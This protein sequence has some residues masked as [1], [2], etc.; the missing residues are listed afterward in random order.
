MMGGTDAM[1]VSERATGKSSEP[2][3]GQRPDDPEETEDEAESG[4][5]RKQQSTTGQDTPSRSQSM[6]TGT[7]RGDAAATRDLLEDE[8][9]KEND[10]TSSDDA[11][12]MAAIAS[13]L[14]QLA[15][16][17]KG[18]RHEGGAVATT[19]APTAA[20]VAD[21]TQTLTQLMSMVADLTASTGND[22]D[23]RQV[24]N[25]EVETE[26]AG[27][28]QSPEVVV[29]HQSASHEQGRVVRRDRG[30]SGREQRRDHSRSSHS[31]DSRDGHGDGR[32]SRQRHGRGARRG[33]RRESRQVARREQHDDAR[34]PAQR[35]AR[36]ESPPSSG[37]DD[38]SGSSSEEERG[39]A[40]RNYEESSSGSASSSPSSSDVSSDEQDQARG[41]RGRDERRGRHGRR[42]RHERRERRDHEP[43]RR[44]RKKSVK[45]L[46]LPTFTPSPKVSVSTWID[47]VELA[48]KGA[49]ESG[50]GTWS[51]KALYFILGNKLMESASKWWVD[52]D[53]RLSDRRR[54]WTY[55]KRALLRRYGEKLDKSAAEWRVSMRRMMPG[56]THADFAAGLRG[57][58]GRNKVSE[59]VLLA[60]FY[61]CLD[62]TTKKLVKQ[63]PKPR[64][65][66]EAVDKATEIDDP[67]DNVA[68]GMANIG[69]AWAIAPSRY[70]I[71]MDGT[72]GQTGV[73]PGISGTGVPTL[74]PA[75]GENGT[76]AA[77][78]VRP[79]ALFTNPQ[80]V[81]NAYSG[82]WDPPPGHLWNGKYWYEPRRTDKKRAA[83][84]SSDNSGSKGKSPAV[85]QKK[86]R[87]R[88]DSSDDG[89]AGRP[90]PRKL[91]AAVRQAA[92]EEKPSGGRTNI[93][94]QR[95]G[96]E[97]PTDGDQ[98]AGP[99]CYRCGQQGH[100]SGQCDLEP[101]CFACH[102]RGHFARDCT[103]SEAKKKNDEYMQ[104]RAV[105]TKKSAGNDG[106]AQ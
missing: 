8:E 84:A 32:R 94:G 95:T 72:T 97:R 96:R 78:D 3:K 21:V 14:Q 27:V 9:T 54:T 92:T 45:D 17:V 26:Q 41:H 65:L 71:P 42:G 7:P 56:E 28:H 101:E 19:K 73:I 31:V 86:R 5:R 20:S 55:L 79:V 81:Y 105:E 47:R 18:L 34:R 69:Q 12:S 44:P 82:T 59:R 74:M 25:G 29:E 104:R 30:D 67:M 88:D 100:M 24:D 22:A 46:E 48:L 89:A 15:T 40:G 87:E 93:T 49:E 6:E 77:G 63:D 35:R 66:E 85:H 51:D 91:K 76:T 102:R 36:H 80:G 1:L 75:G 62:K 16:T 43:G 106:R 83:V 33:E 4:R 53:R 98:T 38:S 57:V 64:T 37:D 99:R 103:D 10:G 70:V 23:N 68:Q 60:Q 50:R 52:M 39:G 58:V 61:R 90:K 2:I 11:V 13:T